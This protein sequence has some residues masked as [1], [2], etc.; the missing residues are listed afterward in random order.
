MLLTQGYITD[1]TVA[2][3][4]FL[5]RRLNK[6]LLVKGPAGVGKT[7]IAKVMAN[8]L[9]TDR[10]RNANSYALYRCICTGSQCRKFKAFR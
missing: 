3:S 9:E 10:I 2:M 1:D 4:V 5:S 8:A 6:P 7:E